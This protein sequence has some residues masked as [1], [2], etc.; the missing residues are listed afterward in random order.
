M[1][2]QALW[3]LCILCLIQGCQTTA[4][5]IDSTEAQSEQVLKIK[6]ISMEKAVA[7]ANSDAIREYKSLA[8]FNIVPCEE[9]VYWRIIYDGGGPE[10]IIDKTSGKILRRQKHPPWTVNELENTPSMGAR[11]RTVSREEAIAIAQKDAYQAYGDKVDLDQFAI[12]VCEQAR[13]WRVNFDY[14]LAP[15]QNME[16]LPNGSFPKYVIDKKT[17]KILYKELG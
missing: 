8:D 15:G 16:H 17:G 13:V 9:V 11:D 2:S 12:I 6:G 7:I 1:T 4:P 5:P 10:Y 3:I 14:K